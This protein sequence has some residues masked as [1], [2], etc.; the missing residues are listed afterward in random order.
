MSSEE[1]GARATL[2]A[3]HVAPSPPMFETT[4]RPLPVSDRPSY[5]YML[6]QFANLRG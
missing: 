6:Q 2:S 4:A 1:A 3:G 5:P